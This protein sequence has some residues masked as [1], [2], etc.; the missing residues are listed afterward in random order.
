M[1]AVDVERFLGLIA[2][3]KRFVL[4]THV[5][6][7]GDGIGS[8]LGLRRLIEAGGGSV[9]IV[10]HDPTPEGLAF[11]DPERC[12]ELYDP[13]R[14]DEAIAA[15]DV[16]VMMDNSVPSRLSGMLEPVQ[17]TG[18]LTACIDH[19]PDPDP[20]WSLLLVDERASC[21]AELVWRLF[22]RQGVSMD[23]PTANRLYAALVSDTGR[24]RFANAN[25]GAFRMAAD[26]VAAGADPAAI[27]GELEERQSDGFLRLYGEILST[28]E[29]RADGRLVILRAPR[30]VIDRHGMADGDL[31]EIINTSLRTRGSC[32]AALFREVDGGEIKVSLRSKGQR[33]V[34]RLAR[35]HGGGGHR[36]ASGIVLD[37]E[38][39]TAVQRLL[40]ELEHLARD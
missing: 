30:E 11:L 39:E 10:N 16:F 21:T 33:N 28:M 25:E 24:F 29:T 34:N 26:L 9:R 40:P 20:F 22:V 15:T 19:H 27:Y 37:E 14:H 8:E 23:P 6:P 32:L 36:N 4:T 17:R 13:A 38:L 12:C 7:D 3:R 5:A 35:A 1:E 18:A 2:E 31:S